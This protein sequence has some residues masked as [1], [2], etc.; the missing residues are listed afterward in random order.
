MLYKFI[1]LSIAVVLVATT[2]CRNSTN[3]RKSNVLAT[4]GEEVLTLS[5]L[6]SFLITHSEE[7]RWAPTGADNRAWLEE[8]L[9]RLAV[10]RL[11]LGSEEMADLLA[12]PET[13]AS[14]QILH[15]QRLNLALSHQ[16]NLEIE[17]SE[18]EIAAKLEELPDADNREPIMDFQHIYFRTDRPDAETVKALAESVAAKAKT[19][20]DFAALVRQYSH[21]A[22][23]KDGGL[24][25]NVVPSNLDQTTQDVLAALEEG[26]ISDLVESRTGLHIFRLIRRVKSQSAGESQRRT[27]AINMIRNE[28]VTAAYAALLE[29]LRQTVAIDTEQEPWQVGGFSLDTHVR[30]QFARGNASRSEDAGQWLVDLALL[31]HEAV[32]RQLA[33]ESL[34]NQVERDIRLGLMQQ[35][36]NRGYEELEQLLP[37][38]RLKPY[39]DAQPAL[40]AIPEK[41]GVALIF[42][43]HGRDS[44]ATQKD[45][46]AKVERLRQGASFPEMA[47][48]ISSGPKAAEGGFQ[49]LLSPQE[50]SQFG[51]NV[52]LAIAQL[53]IGEISNPIFCT[54]RVLSKNPLL[55]RGG[56]AIVKVTERVPEKIRDF[57][58]AIDDVRTS[59][60]TH[61]RKDLDREIRDRMLA[62]A[63]FEIHRIPKPEELAQ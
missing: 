54:G 1:A 15:L 51:P 59:Y 20:E 60:A 25:R 33:T 9:R 27:S 7:S 32:E 62:Q 3:N 44:F 31:A 19:G 43:P 58:E 17:P 48:K 13:R 57:E 22:N 39:F 52:A 42:V 6:D 11:L 37:P 10:E 30:Q 18:A 63:N 56:F 45:L 34:E 55:L 35:L 5:D 23:A 29:Q 36:F 12:K 28:R 46:E 8:K 40:F 14:R 47:K 2:G 24:V 21:S 61:N 26:Q 4:V 53:E 49:G 41:V 50:Y 38:N 16:L